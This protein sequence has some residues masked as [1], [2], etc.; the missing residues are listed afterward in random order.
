MP[1]SMYLCTISCAFAD[2]GVEVGELGEGIDDGPA[3]ER[4]VGEAGALGLLPLRLHP[5]AGGVD[6]G[7]VDLHDAEGVRRGRQ[8]HDHVVAGEPADLGELDHLVALAGPG[9]GRGGLG[10]GLGRRR[11]GAAGASLA[12]GAGAAAGAWAGAAG[13]LRPER[14]GG[15]G[16]DRLGPGALDVVEHVLPGDAPA[17]AGTGDLRRIEPVLVDQPAHH[18]RQE[19]AVATSGRGRL[20]ATASRAG[21]DAGGAATASSAGSAPSGRGPARAR[22]R[23]PALGAAGAAGSGAAGAG[24]SSAAGAGAAWAPSAGAAAGAL[25]ASPTTA[26]TAPTSTT[27]PSLALISVITPAIGEG[28]SVSTLSVDTSKRGSSSLTSSPTFLNQRRI[29]P[30]VTV[31]PSWGIWTSAISRAGSFR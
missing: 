2:A 16:R 11:A 14:R 24:G 1:R 29:V 10:G 21:S 7:V 26:M 12:A 25:P 9:R 6:V 15:R 8:R 18:R 27:S 30:S 13:A 28:T 17:G 19:P 31:S 3:D 23:R 5:V 22:E 20:A 4:E